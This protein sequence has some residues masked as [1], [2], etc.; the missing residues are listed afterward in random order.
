[1]FK[2]LQILALLQHSYKIILYNTC[3]LALQQTEFLFQ[4]KAQKLP[5]FGD[6]PTFLHVALQDITKGI[7]LI[8]VDG[9]LNAEF[10]YL[11]IF[12]KTLVKKTKSITIL[13]A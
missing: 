1:M 9:S 13:I 4:I 12:K 11:H 6:S 10:S 2:T 3:T 7:S 5:H 8:P